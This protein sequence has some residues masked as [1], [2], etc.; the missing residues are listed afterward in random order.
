MLFFI[1]VSSAQQITVSKQIP[2]I[3]KIC[4]VFEQDGRAEFV[5]ELLSK[6]PLKD[7][8]CPACNPLTIAIRASCKL[9]KPD[10][11]K[12]QRDPHPSLLYWSTILGESI[13]EDKNAGYIW[14]AFE[15]LL[16]LLTGDFPNRPPAEK[17]Y[18]TTFQF[19]LL[20]T[21]EVEDQPLMVPTVNVGSLFE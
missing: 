19:Y 2:Y 13:N 16:I 10:I 3:K 12:K 1:S 9:G 8:T 21:K 11:A 15:K 6:T 14:Q 17:E 5:S 4:S 20:N 7:P 18:F